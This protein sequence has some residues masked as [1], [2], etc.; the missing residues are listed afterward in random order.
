LV[1]ENNFEICQY[2]VKNQ[3]A[4]TE[5]FQT[6]IPPEIQVKLITH[7]INHD[8]KK[9]VSEEMEKLTKKININN[10]PMKNTFM[11]DEYLSIFI[12]AKII[13]FNKDDFGVLQ[14]YPGALMAYVITYS[15]E[16][17]DKF[18]NFFKN[19]ITSKTINLI[20]VN[21]NISTAIKQKILTQ[22]AEKIQMGGYEHAIYETITN[23]KLD[24]PKV[25]FLKFQDT[26]K[27][28]ETEKNNLKDR[29][30]TH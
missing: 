14:N 11:N 2:L 24:I 5:T 19:T 26:D 8:Y 6:D 7:I 20:M 17:T 28:D 15:D 16:I 4:L 25:L 23:S 30:P 9:N 1:N 27:L 21:E 13:A 10:V 29:I 12:K 18:D 3:T 22:Y